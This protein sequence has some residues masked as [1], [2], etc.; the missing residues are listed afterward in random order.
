MYTLYDLLS[1]RK[2]SLINKSLI[3]M[4]RSFSSRPH[5]RDVL[6]TFLSLISVFRLT[7]KEVALE[8]RSSFL[9]FIHVETCAETFCIIMFFN[10]GNM[11]VSLPKKLVAQHVYCSKNVMH[12]SVF[13]K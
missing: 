3:A 8:K 7:N 2:A 12:H 10:L 4:L 6:V 13:K 5:T 9:C 1:K 11:Y